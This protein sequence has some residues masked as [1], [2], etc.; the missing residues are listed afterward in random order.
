MW[1]TTPITLFFLAALIPFLDPPGVFSYD[2]NFS[3]TS[4]I[5]ISAFLGFLLQWSGALALGATSAVSHVVLGQ[6]KTCVVL[7]GNYYIFYANPGATS[8]CGAFTAIAGMSVYTYLNL[9]NPKSQSGKASR[10]PS[11]PKSRLSKENGDNSHDSYGGES[12]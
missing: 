10:K 4:L 6:F 11:S 12:V 1:K 3:N 8:I 2:W 9:H 7:L 5:L